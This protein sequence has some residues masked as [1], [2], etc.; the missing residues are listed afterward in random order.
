MYT[1]GGRRVQFFSFNTV[2]SWFHFFK[3]SIFMSNIGHNEQYVYTSYK[4]MGSLQ[5]IMN[6][7]KH[8]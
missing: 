3:K 8:S 4:K 5:D 2:F 1:T 7:T 6:S